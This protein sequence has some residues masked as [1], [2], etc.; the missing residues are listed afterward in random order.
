MIER[1]KTWVRLLKRDTYALYL[2]AR[3]ARVP[4]LAKVL[5]GAV[6]AYA[7]SPIDLIPDFIPVI[8]Y[9][10][11]LLVLPLGIWLSIR[12]VPREVWRE[13]QAAAA[14]GSRG[15]PSSRTAAVVIVAVWFVAAA[16][17]ISWAQEWFGTT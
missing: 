11:D 8:G 4:I 15:L 6:V 2:A 1:W 5:I 12:L 17:F 13:C 16:L 14:E 7:A 9:L 10:D 3:D